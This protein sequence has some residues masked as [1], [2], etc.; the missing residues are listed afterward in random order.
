MQTRLVDAK[1]LAD[2][3]PTAKSQL[4]EGMNHVLKT[5]PNDRDKQVSSY[6][7]PTLPVAPEL[8]RAISKFVNEKRGI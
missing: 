3:N 8:I 6:S 5:V 4:I 2:S 1:R 7:D